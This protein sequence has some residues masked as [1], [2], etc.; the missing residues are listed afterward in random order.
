MSLVDDVNATF[1]DIEKSKR[2]V[3]IGMRALEYNVKLTLQIINRF[4][5]MM[6]PILDAMSHFEDTN[7]EIVK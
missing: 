1:V 6:P 5:E 7:E 4:N 2:E 3:L